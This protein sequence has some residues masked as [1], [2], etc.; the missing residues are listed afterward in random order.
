MSKILTI[1]AAFFTLAFMI[2]NVFAQGSE[3]QQILDINLH[4]NKDEV[5]LVSVNRRLGFLPDYLNQPEKGYSLIVYSQD[6]KELFKVKFNFP[7]E[8]SFVPPPRSDSEKVVEGFKPLTEADMTI[9]IPALEDAVKFKV[10][11]SGGKEILSHDLGL[12]TKPELLKR[13]AG[14]LSP[15]SWPW[16]V[17]LLSLGAIIFFTSAYI[18]LHKTGR[19]L[20]AAILIILGAATLAF[21]AFTVNSKL[22]KLKQVETQPNRNVNMESTQG[23]KESPKDLPSPF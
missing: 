10:F 15:I 14:F 1:F 12:L 6:D 3:K 16:E 4:Y 21:L 7:L 11:D 8:L 23:A 9:T 2:G 5:T 19:K 17:F 20:I 13:G 22:P 18:F